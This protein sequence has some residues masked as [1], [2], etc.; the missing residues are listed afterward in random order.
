M[1]QNQSCH[2]PR[3]VRLYRNK[4]GVWKNYNSEAVWLTQKATKSNAVFATFSL[5]QAKLWRAV[6]C[7]A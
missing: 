7:E 2:T 1:S 6:K 4:I 3:R 5:I